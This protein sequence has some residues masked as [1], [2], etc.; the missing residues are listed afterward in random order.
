MT[1]KLHG[2]WTLHDTIGPIDI[3]A[4]DLID[5]YG[6][7]WLEG[8][9]RVRWNGKIRKTFKGETAFND[10]TRLANDLYYDWRLSQ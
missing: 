2:T 6:K 7:V 5:R 8:A 10:A 4:C 9:W 1:Y 3:E